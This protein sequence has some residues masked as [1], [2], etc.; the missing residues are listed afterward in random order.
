M[1]RTVPQHFADRFVVRGKRTAV[2]ALMVPPLMTASLMMWP[3][4]LPVTSAEPNDMASLI[5]QLAD[6]NQQIEQLTADVQ[7]QQESINKGLVD[8]QDARDNA[9]AAGQAVEEGQRAVDAANGAIVEAQGKFDRMAAATYMAGPS[10]SYLTAT[11]PDDVV[12]LASVTKSVEASSQTVMDNLRRARTEQVNKES[13]ARAIQEKADQAAADAQKQQDDLVSAMKDVQ[14]KLEAQRGTASELA[15]KK[16]SAEAQ[17]A[18]ARGPEFAASTATARVVNPSAAIA[19]NGNEWTEG[20]APAAAAGGQWDTTLPMIASANVPTDP[21]QTINMVLGIGNTAANVGQSAVCG[22]IGMF[23]PKAAP[24]AAASSE[25]GEYIPK[26]YGRENVERVIARAGSAMNT[27]YSW[28]GGSYNGPTRGIDSGANTVGYDCSGLMMYGFAA[29]GIRLRHYTGYQYNSGRKVPSAQM[30]RGDMIFY[31]PNASQHVALYLG[32]GQ[33][34]EAPNTGDVV[35]VSPVRTSGMT[36]F[37]T[38][39]IEW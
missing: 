26:V 29:V 2:V 9:A 11:S 4:T 12:R 8:L 30:K 37:V 18:A 5:T 31:G 6:T 17:L 36:P 13:Q 27:P 35:K 23:C 32:N 19:G 7:T 3:T 28:G 14:K 21:T 24:A 16:K 15:A 25:G 1:K 20:P 39:L 38:R 10:G 22:V 33:M 34:L